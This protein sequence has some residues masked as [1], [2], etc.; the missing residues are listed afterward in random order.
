VEEDKEMWGTGGEKMGEDGDGLGSW[1]GQL[2][3]PAFN[4]YGAPLTIPDSPY[5]YKFTGLQIC[6]VHRCLLNCHLFDLVQIGTSSL[7][8]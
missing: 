7:L 6:K 5:S 4:G 1:R 3:A 8:P 2:M